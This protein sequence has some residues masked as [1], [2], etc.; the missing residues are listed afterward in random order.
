MERA[1]DRLLAKTNLPEPTISIFEAI[2]IKHDFILSLLK[3]ISLPLSDALW[4]DSEMFEIKE[5]NKASNVY[6]YTAY[7][8][9]METG[10][11]GWYTLRA[12]AGKVDDKT[13]RE[14]ALEM[15]QWLGDKLVVAYGTAKPELHRIHNLQKYLPAGQKAIDFEYFDVQQEIVRRL[16]S[17]NPSDE[18]DPNKPIYLPFFGN[19]YIGKHLNKTGKKNSVYAEWEWPTLSTDCETRGKS[20]YDVSMM[21]NFVHALRYVKGGSYFS[22]K[23]Q[24]DVKGKGKEKLTEPP[25]RPLEPASPSSRG[26]TPQKKR[27]IYHIPELEAAAKPNMQ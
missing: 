21:Y 27:K 1:D 12:K 15:E 9:D 13:L 26:N 5:G 3:K 6:E 19:E 7:S 8:E 25:S 24:P 20:V 4:I 22:A 16:F 2:D 18:L 11:G 10:D 17:Y 23:H 14:W